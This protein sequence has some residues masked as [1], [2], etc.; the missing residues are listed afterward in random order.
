MRRPVTFGEALVGTKGSLAALMFPALEKF[1]A[2]VAKG[3]KKGLAHKPT[4]W[5][6]EFYGRIPAY[7]IE[8]TTTDKSDFEVTGKVHL[9][10]DFMTGFSTTGL[11]YSVDMETKNAYTGQ[12][13]HSVD[14]NAHHSAKEAVDGILTN[15]R[16]MGNV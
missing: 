11:N 4:K 14:M 12:Q 9:I 7:F 3:V 16:D 6:A 1:G 5:R 15:L 8:F 13:K 10:F 2:E